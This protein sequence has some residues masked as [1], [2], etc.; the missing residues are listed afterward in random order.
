MEPYNAVMALEKLALAE[1]VVCFDNEALQNVCLNTLGLD[2]P[3]F[4]DL[5][6]LVSMTMAGATASFRFPGS[7][8]TD[9]SNQYFVSNP[10]SVSHEA[11]H[12][13][14]LNVSNQHFLG[15]FRPWLMV[16]LRHH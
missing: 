9:M 13:N 7:I 15:V 14:C 16:S 5:N 10:F 1:N 2:S 6:R 3:T 11:I 8:N 12:L 4:G